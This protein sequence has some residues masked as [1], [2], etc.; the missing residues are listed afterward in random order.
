MLRYRNHVVSTRLRKALAG[1]IVL[2]MPLAANA[3]TIEGKLP[4][5]HCASEGR[6]CPTNKLDPHLAIEVEFVVQQPGGTYYFI[7]NLDRAIKARY[8]LDD[9]RVSGDLNT[10][11]KTVRADKLEIR[12]GYTYGRMDPGMAVTIL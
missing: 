4:G 5:L 7:P 6:A 2:L 9:V 1:L 3:D 8:V 11:Y 12:K 10:Q